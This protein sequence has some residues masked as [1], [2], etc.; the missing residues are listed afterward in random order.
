MPSSSLCRMP[1]TWSLD[2][3]ALYLLG[4]AAHSS[5]VPPSPGHFHSPNPSPGSWLCFLWTD[6]SSV[7]LIPTPDSTTLTPK[8]TPHLCSLRLD[9]EL[10]QIRPLFPVN[11]ALQTPSERPCSHTPLGTPWMAMK[12]PSHAQKGRSPPGPL[13][14]LPLSLD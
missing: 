3:R 2:R 4:V 7:F 9:A 5:L 10:L 14:L 6:A 12:P 11:Q 1:P 8:H 13:H